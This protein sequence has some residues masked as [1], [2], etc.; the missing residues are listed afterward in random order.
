MFIPSRYNDHVTKQQAHCQQ[1]SEI[2]FNML[3]NPQSLI[4]VIR[5]CNCELNTV[6]ERI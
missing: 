1:I 2:K 3:V 6:L 4:I 5:A